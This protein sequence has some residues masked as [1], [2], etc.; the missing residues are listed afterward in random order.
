[1][2]LGTAAQIAHRGIAQPGIAHPKIAHPGIAHLGT[3]CLMTACLLC[4]ATAGAHITRLDIVAQ[5]DFAGGAAFGAAGPFVRIHAIAHGELDPADPANAVIAGLDHAPRTPNDTVAYDTDVEI[6]RPKDP[7]RGSG[8]LLFDVPNRGNKYALSWLDDT[9]GQGLVNDPRTEA[10]AGNRFTFSRGYTLVWAGWQPEVHGANLLG[11][12][13]PTEAGVQQPIRF[14]IEAGTRGPDSVASIPLPYPAAT[15]DGASLTVRT[16]GTDP[17]TPL[18]SGDWTMTANQVRLAGAPFTPRRIY[19]LRYQ[20][21]GPTVDGIGFAAVRDVVAFLRRGDPAAGPVKHTLGFGVSLSGRF[22]RNFLEMGMNRAEDGSRVFDGVL[23]HISGAGKVFDNF[24]FAMPGRTATMH[25][26]RFYPENWFPFATFPATD[27]MTGQ[28]GRLLR[29]DGSDPL[30]IETNTS[31]EYWQ[32]GASLIHTDPQDGTDRTLP[33]G[34]RSFLV[35][36]T[37]HGGHSGSPTSTGPCVLGRNPH[38]AGPALRA[39]L[40]DLELWVTDGTAPPAS[41]VPRQA[42][43]TAAPAGTIRMP[44]I[45][46]VQWAGTANRIGPPVDWVNPPADVTRAYPTFVAAV[47]ADG[48]ERAGLRLPEISVPLGTYTGTNL[49]RDAPGELCD[50][51]GSFVPFARTAEERTRTGDP[52]PSLTERYGSK[53]GYVARVQQAAAALVAQRLML[54]ADA[55]AATQAAEAIPAFP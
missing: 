13:V 2:K 14:E 4:P 43:G 19:E 36:G 6:L 44:A 47:D 49:Y 26:D 41:L 53:P 21:T 30:I 45:T 40:V 28:T 34:V 15:I 31:T 24:A 5:E 16:R 38:S 3:A 20:A 11:I 32:K 37:Q 29:G 35:A 17:E 52:R 9:P 46:G 55:Q 42:D 25:E 7:A 48:N 1:M 27:P 23:P 10:D 39:L 50:R 54:P 18:A 51:D 12:R 8:T 22:L 33:D